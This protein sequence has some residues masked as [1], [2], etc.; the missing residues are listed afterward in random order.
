MGQV[1]R[2]TKLPLASTI[3]TPQPP[4]SSGTSAAFEL[5]TPIR[6]PSIVLLVARSWMKT[7]FLAFAEMTFQPIVLLA[8]PWSMCTPLL[9][10]RGAAPVISVPM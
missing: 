2:A 6:L 8:E 10:P 3:C 7:P 5:V 1:G 9:L 4:L